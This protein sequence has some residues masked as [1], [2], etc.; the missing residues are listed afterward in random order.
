MPHP[1]LFVLTEHHGILFRSHRLLLVVRKTI[2]LVSLSVTSAV[3][4]DEKGLRVALSVVAHVRNAS[5]TRVGASA[6]T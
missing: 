3:V 6:P 4:K 2:P 5:M 1:R